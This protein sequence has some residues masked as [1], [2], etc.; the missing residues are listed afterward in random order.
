MYLSQFYRGLPVVV[1]G[2]AGFIGSNLV[3]KLVELGARVTVVDALVPGSGAHLFNLQGLQDKIRLNLCS[4]ESQSV[5]EELLRDQAV[6]FNLAGLVSHVESMRDPSADLRANLLAHLHLLE[7]ARRSN[8]G[9]RILYAA[10]RQQ[11]GR[12]RALPVTEDHPLRPT[13]LNGVHKMAAEAYHRVYHTAYGLW[14]ASL[15]LTNTYGPRQRVRDASQGFVGW[16]IRL[17]MEGRSIQIYGDGTQ[18]RDLNYVEDVVDAFLRLGMT[19][20][21][22]GESYNLGSQ[23][24][25]LVEIAEA[26]VRAAGSGRIE[27]VPFPEERKAIDI[28]NYYGS[29]SQ[30]NRLTGWQPSTSMDEGF[31]LT[32]EFYRHYREHYW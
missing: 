31:K 25:T 23:P 13:D 2:G 26:A 18:L 22:A 11:Y 27:L 30:I 20:G 4:L 7:A 21:G 12:P 5:M 14:T 19:D 6:V 8:P 3:R 16:F 29:Y 1:T 9:V 32:V 15:R 10:T 28:G 17:A 24:Y